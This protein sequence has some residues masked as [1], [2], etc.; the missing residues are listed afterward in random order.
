M[1]L[2][3][4]VVAPL[5][6]SDVE[7]VASAL[8][9]W[10][11]VI[12]LLERFDESMQLFDAALGLGLAPHASL[13]RVDHGSGANAETAG[14]GGGGGGHGDEMDALLAQFEEK[15]EL[16]EALKYDLLIYARAKALFERQIAAAKKGDKRDILRNAAISAGR[17]KRRSFGQAG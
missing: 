16:N 8:E 17:E 14:G 3:R 9:R 12:G 6:P 15:P 11:A 10:F 13:T 7:L 1:Q 2:D 4:E 5:A